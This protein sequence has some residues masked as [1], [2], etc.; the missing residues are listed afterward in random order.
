[1]ILNNLCIKVYSFRVH[2]LRFQ[3]ETQLQNDGVD[4]II[5]FEGLIFKSTYLPLYY[6]PQKVRSYLSPDVSNTN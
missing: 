3:S 2:F 5:A 1:M 4:W 6:G